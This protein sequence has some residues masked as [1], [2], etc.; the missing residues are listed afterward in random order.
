M[1]HMS[2]PNILYI[3]T[4]QQRYDSLSLVGQSVCRTPHLDQLARSGVFF[5]Q[6]YSI[7]ALCS[8]ARASMLSGLYPRNHRMWNNN[9]MMQWAVRDLPDHVRMISQDLVEAGYNCG[10]SGKWH[11]GERKLPQHYGFVG[12]QVPN[13]GNPYKTPEYVAYLQK[14]HLEPPERLASPYPWAGGALSGL[15]EATGTYFVA[16]YALGLLQ[17]FSQERDHTGRPFM[18]FVSFWGPHHPCRIPEPY[19]SMYDPRDIAVW[20][21][22]DDPLENKPA[23]QHRHRRSFY[24]EG[25]R[26]P[27]EAWQQIIAWYWGYCTFVDDQIGRLLSA[28]EDLGRSDDTIVLFSTDHGDMTG[29][30]GGFWDKGPFMYQETYHI[31][32]IIRVPGIA[33]AGATRHQFVSNMDLAPT[34]LDLAGLPVPKEHDGHSLAPLL[35]DPDVPWPDDLMCEFHGHRFL[36]SQRMLR[37]S[38]YKFIYNACDED[39][40]YDLGADPYELHNV[41]RDPAYSAIADEGRERMLRRIQESNDPLWFAARHMLVHGK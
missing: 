16:D 23:V 40:L 9:D 35:T 38:N 4:D 18:L 26:L 31:P 8:P 5:D 13:Y 15:P 10:Y 36:Y 25:P 39:E 22:L 19:T 33:D 32:L 6:A 34:V 12:M 20:P 30:H 11:C 37:W 27:E 2:Q 1:S 28:L 41:I 24:P 14:H 21:N 17:E 3:M 7:C 29:A